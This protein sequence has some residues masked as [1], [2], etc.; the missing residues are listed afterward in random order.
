MLKTIK[1]KINYNEIE[2]FTLENFEELWNSNETNYGYNFQYQSLLIDKSLSKEKVEA[3]C[4]IMLQPLLSKEIRDEYS[5]LTKKRWDYYKRGNINDFKKAQFRLREI[6]KQLSDNSRLQLISSIIEERSITLF[7]DNYSTI[8]EY[9]TIADIF[10]FIKTGKVREGINKI[11]NHSDKNLRKKQ[12]NKLP[13][14]L[15]NGRFH[16]RDAKCFN[17]F[18]EFMCLDFDGFDSNVSIDE[19][20]DKISND[21]YVLSV[22][23]SPSGNGLKVII[24]V[25]QRVSNEHHLQLFFGAKEYF[26]KFVPGFD[27][28]CKSK[29]HGCYLSYDP[30]IRVN[31][32]SKVK[33]FDSLGEVPKKANR[34]A[35]I[36]ENDF[37]PSVLKEKDFEF[38]LYNLNILAID[39]EDEIINTIL[40]IWYSNSDNVLKEGNTHTPLNNLAFWLWCNG[41][42]KTRIKKVFYEEFI[43]VAD[44]DEEKLNKKIIGATNNPNKFNIAVTIDYEFLNQIKSTLN[45]ENRL[46]ELLFERGFDI[47]DNDVKKELE[48]IIKQANN[49]TFWN[50]IVQAD[51]NGNKTI[52]GYKPSSSKLIKFLKAKNIVAIDEDRHYTYFKSENNILTKIKLSDVKNIIMCYLHEKHPDNHKL[53]D[54]FTSYIYKDQLFSELLVPKIEKERDSLG[55]VK[56]YFSNGVLIIEKGKSL[57]IDSYQSLKNP[58]LDSQINIHKIDIQCNG[59]SDYKKFVKNI[60]G[61]NFDSFKSA[62]GYLCTNHKSKSDAKAII[63]ND[64]TNNFREANGRTGKGLIG[65]AIKQVTNFFEIDGKKYNKDNQFA[66]AGVTDECEIV[67]I[68]DVKQSVQ[69]TTF[70]NLI[71]DSFEIR[72]MYTN[73]YSIP[74]ESS[75]KLLISTNY[76]ILGNDGSSK[77]RR[78][79]LVLTNYYSDTHTPIDDFEKEFFSDEWTYDEWN[80]FYMFMIEC[81][82][83]YLE[84]GLIIPSDEIMK[85]KHLYAQTSEDFVKFMEDSADFYLEKWTTFEEIKNNYFRF[86][87]HS[88]NNRIIGEWVRT[89][90][91]TMGWSYN[92]ERQ[93]INNA[94]LTSIYIKKP[95]SNFS[96]MLSFNLEKK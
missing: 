4:K 70:Y 37:S 69:F 84:N 23:T 41:I 66:L 5:T 34:K 63:L 96:N 22:F 20:K 79:D 31:D 18:S 51:K 67:F 83:F 73:P 62:I 10:D 64:P 54:L 47:Y 36:S 88:K 55:I 45:N 17:S 75:P 6:A 59:E 53:L 19:L 87:N 65:E 93:I 68:N 90:C 27:I 30:D 56:K 78:L 35:I 80:N 46:N 60:S 21:P 58:I 14:I 94:K 39:D 81:I 38:N 52:K 7:K 11:R 3:I 89:W 86:S 1:T 61:D 15:F 72:K 33:I 28:A 2:N 43:G 9:Y 74:F 92:Q 26:E 85:I 76:P 95:E 50:E 91:K 82:Q 13:Q 25:P 8:A 29:T 16:S 71:T 42:S 44:L 32:I 12:K 77:A 49:Y 24:K 57:K 48:V 40:R